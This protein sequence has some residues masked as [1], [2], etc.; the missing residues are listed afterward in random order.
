MIPWEKV[1]REM[2]DPERS[3]HLDQPIVITRSE[4]SQLVLASRCGIVGI[5]KTQGEAIRDLSHKE[6]LGIFYGSLDSDSGGGV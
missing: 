5:G 3:R 1:N 2:P 4:A 6:V